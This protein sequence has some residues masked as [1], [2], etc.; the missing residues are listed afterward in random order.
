[1]V[2]PVRTGGRRQKVTSRIGLR[3][4]GLVVFGGNVFAGFTGLVFLVMAARWLVP[5]QLGLWE[6]IVD[7]LAFS[8]YP[9]GIVAYWATRDVARGRLVGKT[10]FAAAVI[11]SSLGILVYFVFAALTRST[12]ATSFVPFLLGGLLVPL[13][14]VNLVTTSIVLGYRPVVNGYQL[15]I[16]E[17]IKIAVAYLA[18]YDYHLGIEGVI[19]GLL[20][21]YL[22]TSTLG[23]Y[24]VR[25]ATK[26]QLQLSA[27]ERWFRLSWV[28]AIN[29]LPPLLLLADTYVASLG[30]GTSVA[31]IYQPA[32][33]VA[34][35]VN[36]SYYI[37]YSLYSLLLKGG[38]RNLPAIV[39]EFL[40]IFSI[41]M[42]TGLAILAQP[43]LHLFGTKYL[44]G[45]LGLP[46]L[47][48][49]CLFQSI[50]LVVDRTLLGTE[51]VDMGDEKNFGTYLRSNLLYVSVVNT[52][53]AAVYLTGM[54]LALSFALSRG[55][56]TSDAVALWASVQLCTTIVFLAIKARRASRTAILFQAGTK[57]PFYLGAAL[58]MGIALG[59]I[60]RV[61]LFSTSGG[62]TY[63]LGLF[64]VIIL[65]GAIYFGILYAVEPNFRE[66]ALSALKRGLQMTGS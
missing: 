18:L 16:S 51:K 49:M 17:P 63:G 36:A 52:C 31:G 8:S 32:F 35:V 27:A 66:M 3:S 20:T 54:Y 58:A 62:L 61:F 13:N 30:F 60:S 39:V 14:Y 9:I 2:G 59:P 40:L 38:N 6:V 4:T 1:M 53:A 65:G 47:A 55:L 45:S 43:M 22:V 57:V 64:V 10:A 48:F 44:D 50:S 37:S 33:A 56:G 24:M 12:L 28:P 25:G 46:I 34:G 23:A 5:A 41:P 15:V 7:L 11:M 19:L 21:S 26:E 42:A 29:S